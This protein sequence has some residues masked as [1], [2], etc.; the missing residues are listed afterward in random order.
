VIIEFTA[1][2]DGQ[3]NEERK[4]E[5]RGRGIGQREKEGEEQKEKKERNDGMVLERGVVKGL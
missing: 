4:K 2:M 1:D 5:Q 3:R